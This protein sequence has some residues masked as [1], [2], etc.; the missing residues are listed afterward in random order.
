MQIVWVAE[1]QGEDGGYR[2][3]IYDS[4]EQCPQTLDVVYLEPYFFGL[5][6]KR[7]TVHCWLFRVIPMYW[8]EKGELEFVRNYC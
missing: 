8:N 4:R 5:L 2:R 3:R 7:M 6:K 1:F